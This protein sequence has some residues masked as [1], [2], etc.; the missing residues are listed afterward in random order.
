MGRDN[1]LKSDQN[2]GK[3]E[4]VSSELE[5]YVPSRED[6]FIS[7]LID[8]FEKRYG[9]RGPIESEFRVDCLH[10]TVSISKFLHEYSEESN[11]TFYKLLKGKI[12]NQ[13]DNQIDNGAE[14]EIS[15]ANCFVSNFLEKLKH[16][17]FLDSDQNEPFSKR[18]VNTIEVFL[19]DSYRTPETIENTVYHLIVAGLLYINITNGNIDMPLRDKSKIDCACFDLIWEAGCLFGMH[20]EGTKKLFRAIA[21]QDGKK[22]QKDLTINKILE[23]YKSL[24]AKWC[25]GD[26][27]PVFLNEQN[28]SINKLAGVI[29]LSL[30]GLVTQRHI[31]NCLQELHKKKEI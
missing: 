20:E 16:P 1:R 30:K 27:E 17:L 8:F 13:I 14:I 15:S 3:D 22:K 12:D 10:K 23:C 18:F 9:I 26:R 6:K 25:D 31:Y 24:G 28:I 19:G 29:F 2:I 21:V 7:D 4:R 5:K 11:R